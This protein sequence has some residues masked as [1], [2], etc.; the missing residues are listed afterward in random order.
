MPVIQQNGFDFCFDPG[1][2]A[3]CRGGCCRGSTGHVWVGEKD[4]NRIGSFLHINRVDFI[5]HFVNRVNNRLSLKEQ[6]IDG[7]YACVFFE[8]KK[9]SCS[10]YEVRPQQCRSFPFWDYFKDNK[11]ELCLECPGVRD[12]TQAK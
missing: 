11:E 10:I 3:A 12:R 7:D 2:C 5:R 1:A 8:S 9:Q 6:S 4:I